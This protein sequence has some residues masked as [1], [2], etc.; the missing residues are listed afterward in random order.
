MPGYTAD[1]RHF[2]ILLALLCTPLASSCRCDGADSVSRECE[3]LVEEILVVQDERRLRMGQ[4]D[5]VLQAFEAGDIPKPEMREKSS[6]WKV[7]EHD[8][9]GRVSDLYIEARAKGCL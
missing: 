1:L 8:L 9:R 6:G 7:A 4:I 5:E 3:A 2:L